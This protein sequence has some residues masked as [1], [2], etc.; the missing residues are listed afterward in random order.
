MV[1]TGLMYNFPHVYIVN[2][3]LLRIQYISLPE[4]NI[5]SLPFGQL[6]HVPYHPDSQRP[7]LISLAIFSASASALSLAHI[8]SNLAKAALTNS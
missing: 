3:D 5:I 8:I 7:F 6:R 4:I 1:G 2:L